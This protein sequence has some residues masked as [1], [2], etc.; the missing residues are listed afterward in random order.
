L[1]V[2]YTLLWNSEEFGYFMKIDERLKTL[3][4]EFSGLEEAEK[5]Y[6]LGI[7]QVLAHSVAE[8]G[9]KPVPVTGIYE[10]NCSNRNIYVQNKEYLS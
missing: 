2:S 1:E 4:K 8:K 6:I 10:V 5:D 7:S 9:I 3:C